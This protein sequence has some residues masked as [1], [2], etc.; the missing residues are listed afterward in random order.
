MFVCMFCAQVFIDEYEMSNHL[1]KI[2]GIKKIGR[3]TKSSSR[4]EIPMEDGIPDV[5]KLVKRVNNKKVFICDKCPYTV[6]RCDSMTKH[7]LR[8]HSK[9][10]VEPR[11]MCEVC[12]K[13][14]ID[15]AYLRNHGLT[16]VEE[17]QFFCEVVI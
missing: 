1:C 16:H 5:Q 14:F 2:H 13:T 3:P 9:G 12:G 6:M 11:Y 8:V 17:P 4:K 15:Q 10:L 7:V